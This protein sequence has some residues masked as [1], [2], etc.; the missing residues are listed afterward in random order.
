MDSGELDLSV[1]LANLRPQLSNE[2]YVFISLNN[3]SINRVNRL[4]PIATI[5]EKEGTTL[6]ITEERA[7]SDNLEYDTVFKCITLG[8]HS[9]LKSVGLINAISKCLSDNDI[10][11]NVISGYFHDHLFIQNDL[12]KRAMDLLQDIKTK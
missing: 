10:P 5:Q 3:C 11:C 12:S 4:D 2:D 6:V 9:S 8:V 1:I 7:L